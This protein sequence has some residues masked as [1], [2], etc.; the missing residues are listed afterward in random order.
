MAQDLG[1]GES[2]T[3]DIFQAY[4]KILTK[5][6]Q[7]QGKKLDR[8]QEKIIRELSEDIAEAVKDF[9]LNQTF[10]IQKMVAV[11]ELEK[12]QT[13]GVRFADVLPT[14]Q[15]LV[16]IIPCLTLVRGVSQTYVGAVMYPGT[17]G[18][19]GLG[20]TITPV[21]A[22]VVVGE[23]GVMLP[24]L[25]LRKNGGQGGAMISKGYAYVGKNPV[26]GE[27]NI[28]LSEVNLSKEDIKGI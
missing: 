11:L 22:P 20:A 19:T 4:R 1:K 3:N 5:F 14:V 12:L 16:P 2:L 7:R 10:R 24:K 17:V 23:K 27:R 15:T 26:S 8:T 18:G 13:A 28:Y 21:N 9:I 6:E 25:N